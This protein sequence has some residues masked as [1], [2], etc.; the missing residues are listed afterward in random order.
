[1]AKDHM[2]TTLMLLYSI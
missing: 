2:L 1:M